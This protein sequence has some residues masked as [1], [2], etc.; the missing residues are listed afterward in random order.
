MAPYDP[1]GR[2]NRALLVGMSEYDF[3]GP[4]HG[5]PGDLPAVKHNVIRMREVLERGGVFDEGE[6]RVAHSPSQDDFGGA[7]HRA[8]QEAEG[9]LLLYFAGHGAIPSAADELHLQLRNARVVAEERTVFPGAETLTT[10][11]TV[12]TT[13]RARRIVVILDCCFAGNA[14]WVL[15]TFRERSRVLLLMSVQ[16]NNR[17]DAGD[18]RTPTPFTAELVALLGEETN[19]GVRLSEL[20]ERLR[21]RMAA[22][23]HRTM[24]GEPWVPLLKAENSVDVLLTRKRYGPM[25]WWGRM[26]IRYVRGTGPGGGPVRSGAGPDGSGSGGGPVT[27]TTPVVT[28]PPPPPP[29]PPPGG[30]GGG[31]PGG[32]SGA[33]TRPWPLGLLAALLGRLRAVVSR[34]GNARPT[35]RPTDRGG[36]EDGTR[37]GTSGRGSGGRPAGGSGRSSGRRSALRVVLPAVFVAGLLGLGGYGLHGFIGADSAPCAPALELRLLTD[38]DLEE[39]VR[40]AADAYVTSDENTT[41]DGCRRTG[42]T[43]YSAGS[44]DVVGALRSRT[45]AWHEPHD[46]DVNPQ[47]DIGPQ[48]DIWI[49][50]SRADADRA[51]DGRDTDAVATLEPDE[52]PLAYSPVVLAVPH[53]IGSEALNDR[54]GRTLTEM[55]D[56]LTARHGNAA[57]RRPDPEYTDVGLLATVGLYG[58][59]ARDVSRGERLVEQ[60]GSPSPTAADLLCTLPGNDAVDDRTAAL[61]PEF[62]L[63][64]GVGCA[65]TARSPRLAQ[66]PEDVPGVEPV[67]VRVRWRNADRDEQDRDAS[68]DGFRAWL[69]GEGGRAVF[70]RQGFRAADSREPLDPDEVTEHGMLSAPTP[71]DESAGRDAMA[72]ALR[73]YQ[74]AG[75]PG[76][77][78][79]LLDSS[80]SM[81]D[82]WEGPSGAPGLLRQSLGGLGG[83]DEYGVWAVADIG[84]RAHETL[85]D[86]A[87]HRRADADRAVGTGA[88]VR[89]AE[90]DPYAALL[91]ALDEMKSRGGGDGRP[92][93]IVHITDDED[94]DRLTGER[95][96][97]VLDRA[98]TSRVPVTVVSLQNGGCDPDRADHRIADVSGGRCLD[99]GDDLGADLQDEVARAGTGEG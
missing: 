58:A 2:V 86:L 41:G 38:P 50:A 90:A 23:G 83:R 14:A 15:E 33:R 28:P 26:R 40:A 43:V 13:S 17:I 35:G 32:P 87:P 92:Q 36:T 94:N 9:L 65:R 80:G 85:L 88:R 1:R 84:G 37:G 96:D 29:P 75:G 39:T 68:V 19:D 51:E 66:Y 25:P 34:T 81:D 99:A 70:A 73:A 22:R 71:L 61:V 67:F 42:V 6:I 74:D 11:L 7:L 97:E 62:L 64:S 30:S 3:T 59:E 5:V 79:F 24:R 98:R 27:T 72:R 47:R 56:D 89:D 4:P 82:R 76:R 45:G 53:A 8:A 91:A 16:A 60:F 55:I 44:S 78:L 77:V 54:T 52:E 93:L 46:E 20:A 49:P 12:L 95:L 63:R 48:P 57:V 31:P 10:V 21:D 18:G 69:T